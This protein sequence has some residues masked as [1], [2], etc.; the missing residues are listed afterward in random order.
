M[1]YLFL[2]LICVTFNGS[3]A[4]IPVGLQAP[5]FSLIGFDGNQVTLKSSQSKITIVNFWASWCGPCVKSLHETIIPLYNEYSRDQLDVIGI[6]N[7]LKEDKWRAAIDKH[8]IP[9]ANVWDQNRALVKAYGVPAIPT[10]FLLDTSG[11]I[12]QSNIY[13]NKLKSAVKKALQKSYN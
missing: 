3:Q 11:K 4:Q 8:Q 9:W 5:D 12:I 7:D 10:Y 13:A 6:S 1:K 2:F